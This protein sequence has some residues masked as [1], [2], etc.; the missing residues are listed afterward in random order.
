ME[1]EHTN[2]TEKRERKNKVQSGITK[3]YSIPS[4]IILVIIAIIIIVLLLKFLFSIFMIVLTSLNEHI[5]IL[6]F[7]I[8]E[9]RM[10]S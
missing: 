1:M 9:L 2:G 8:S 10:S 4:G 7:V 5:Q 3:W 6:N